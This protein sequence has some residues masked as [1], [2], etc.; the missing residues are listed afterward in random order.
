MPA[1]IP[2]DTQRSLMQLDKDDWADD[3]VG[4][5]ILRREKAFLFPNGMPE[6]DASE[7]K[8]LQDSHMTSEE[9]STCKGTPQLPSSPASVLDTDICVPPANNGDKKPQH[10]RSCHPNCH[11]SFS[12]TTDVARHMA[13]IHRGK[14]PHVCPAVGCFQ[15]NAP[16]RFPRPDKLTD[17]VRNRHYRQDAVFRCHASECTDKGSMSLAEIRVHLEHCLSGRSLHGESAMQNAALKQRCPIWTCAKEM[18]LDRFLAHVN[19]HMLD[20]YDTATAVLPDGF[21]LTVPSDRGEV[22]NLTAFIV[23]P[24]ASCAAISETKAHFGV[25]LLMEHLLRQDQASKQ[26]FAAGFACEDEQSLVH[27]KDYRRHRHHSTQCR[28]C[29]KHTWDSEHYNS[30][31]KPIEDVVAEL[32]PH[33]VQVLRLCPELWRH[34]LY[35][36]LRGGKPPREAPWRYSRGSL[37]MDPLIR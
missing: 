2:S 35:D 17:H 19:T 11:L 16:H 8:A 12:R 4:R 15:G 9:R 27:M 6:V 36:Y 28:A 29:T 18:K 26:H 13:S 23:C 34:P 37:S 14:R 10:L 33:R 5:S 7:A 24:V 21:G 22:A 1:F 25:H 30:H 3:W 31:F 20:E 32:E